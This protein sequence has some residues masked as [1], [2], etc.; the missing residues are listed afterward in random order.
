LIATDLGRAFLLGSIPIAAALGVLGLSQLFVVGF[1][2]ATL[3]VF[4]NVAYQSLIPSLVDR[5][6]LIEANGKLGTSASV[7][8]VAGPGVAGVLIQIVTAPVTIVLDAFSF[9]ASA[10]LIQGIR[11]TEAQPVQQR[12][13]IWREISEGLRILG[14]QPVL[15]AIALCA[16]LNNLAGSAF[17]AVYL[18][19]LTRDLELPPPTVG[20][21]LGAVGVGAIAGSLLS[22]PATQR[23]GIGTTL[24]AGVCLLVL[25]RAC[26]PAAGV[27]PVGTIPLLAL[28]QCGTGFAFALLNVPTSS[29]RQAIVPD[30]LRGR[31]WASS[32]TVSF[33]TMPVG[34]LLGGALGE[35]IGVWETLAAAALATV[36]V[37][38][39]VVL[40]PIPSLREAPP[41]MAVPVSEP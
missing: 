37:V 6:E 10:W 23:L 20:L 22:S 31:V 14:T 15:R 4:F 9:L 41:Q 32:Q 25:A 8:Q 36:L 39:A 2:A 21:V 17:A 30:Q 28:G 27:S 12:R 16:S 7:A 19:Y 40:S 34:A 35:T 33:A 26:A 3:T 13:E 38:L 29:L 5:S 11:V 24:V 1:L 18:V